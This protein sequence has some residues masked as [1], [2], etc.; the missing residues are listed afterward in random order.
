MEFCS[1]RFITLI[2]GTYIREVTIILYKND[3]KLNLHWEN[4]KPL[5]YVLKR[6]LLYVLRPVLCENK[7]IR[8][9]INKIKIIV[10]KITIKLNLH[11]K[12]KSFHCLVI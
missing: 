5:Y 11:W 7:Y 3:M 1:S 8:I 10:Q 6:K 12:Q 4:Q 9:N 2:I